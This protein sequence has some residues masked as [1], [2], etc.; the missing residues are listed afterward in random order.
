M[1]RRS[2]WIALM[3]IVVLGGATRGITLAV[4]QWGEP[5]LGDSIYYHEQANFLADGE[6][7]VE[8]FGYLETGVWKPSAMHPPGYATALAVVSFFGG[9]SSDT[10]RIA[11]VA[12]GTASVLVI[13]LLGRRVG[14]GSGSAERLG[15]LAAFL[16]A[17]APNLF[18]LDEHLMSESLA[19]LLVAWFL[20]A[21]YRA[22]DRPTW[23]RFAVVGLA[24]ALALLT[25]SEAALL[26]PFV[27]IPLAVW[28]KQIEGWK[29]RIG[30]SAVACGVALVV[31]AP[32]TIRNY[33]SFEEPTL[34]GTN[35][36]YTLAY[37]NCDAVYEGRF[38]GY[39]W[40]PCATPAAQYPDESVATKAAR[41]QALEYIAEHKDRLPSVVTA[42]VLR[43]ASLWNPGDAIEIELVG[44]QRPRWIGWSGLLQW[45]L[46]A[47]ASI[48]G[49]VV[50][51]R[52][53]RP[54]FPLVA[55]FVIVAVTAAMLYGFTRIRVPAELAACVLSAVAVDALWAR[56][57]RAP[58]GANDA[59]GATDHP[60]D[61]APVSV[62]V[63]G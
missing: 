36:G 47:L 1:S 9:R 58:V 3:A 20:L 45:Y 42:R 21:V 28:G 13:G 2:F 43:M 26:F 8:P 39:W 61:G 18:Q 19:V 38:I 32:W 33:L 10:H 49:A 5:P 34:L 6:G 55:P 7:Y 24:G 37:S 30:L 29:P 25:R 31:V 12:M 41:E 22:W 63:G 54:I 62:S 11:T 48:A 17:I 52:R 51:R 46:Y 53:G 44:D 40:F 14:R 23:L 27:V 15:L 57:R 50:L 35:E 56:H 16:A 59:D 60:A 4:T